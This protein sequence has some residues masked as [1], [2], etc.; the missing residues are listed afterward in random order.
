LPSKSIGEPGATLLASSYDVIDQLTP[1]ILAHR[2]RGT[3]AGLLQEHPDNR[4]PQQ[5]RL[6]SYVLNASF[7]RAAP[8]SLADG[9]ATASAPPQV[10]PAGGLVIATAPDE[11]LFAGLGVT[12]TFTTEDPGVQAGILNVEE[13]RFVNGTWKNIRWLNGDETHQGRHLRLPPGRMSMQRIKLYR[14][15]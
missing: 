4:Q 13:G 2:G 1:L 10:W 11:F 12:V 5:L 15:R 14:Y 9:T 7:E 8:P 3:M 6:S